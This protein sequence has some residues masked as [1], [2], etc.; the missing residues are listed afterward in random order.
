M[1]VGAVM[2][3]VATL[4][5]SRRETMVR[6]TSRI[7]TT[8]V[9]ALG[10]IALTGCRESGGGDAGGEDGVADVDSSTDDSSDGAGEDSD[11][12]A[13]D[14]DNGGGVDGSD[15]QKPASVQRPDPLY[16]S[17]SPFN[18]RIGSS[19][20]IDPNSSEMIEG[21]V[22][23]FDL[24]G[25]S[26]GVRESAI[27]VYE[28]NADTPVRDVRLAAEWTSATVFESIPVPDYAQP[29]PNNDREMALF[30]PVTRCEYDFWQVRNVDGRWVAS[31]AN[32]ISLDG[33]GF[34]SLSP[35]GARAGGSG[36]LGGL[37]WPQELTDGRIDHAL[38]FSHGETKSGG[39]VPPANQTDGWSDS[40]QAIPEGALLQLD[41]SFD[42]NSLQYE[43]ERVIALALQEYGMYLLDSTAGGLQLYAVNPL[44][45][46]AE[47]YELTIPEERW[48]EDQWVE[49]TIPVDRFRVLEMGPQDPDPPQGL[50]S[51]AGCGVHSGGG[52][53]EGVW[54]LF[55]TGEHAYLAAGVAG[56]QIV[57]VSDPADP[58]LVG[59]VGADDLEPAVSVYVSGH[60]AYVGTDG[61]G[62]QIIDVSDP[63][64]PQ[65]VGSF[66]EDDELSIIG[67][68][69]H[70][71]TAYA[72]GDASFYVLDV[73]DPADPQEVGGLGESERLDNVRDVTIEGNCNRSRAN[74]D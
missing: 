29:D 61:S 67:V 35:G 30:D 42:I 47:P 9:F 10:I 21:L 39:P 48:E 58:K 53:R 8:I 36:L 32:S 14:A 34:F 57:D 46:S 33:T 52:W 6:E 55:V 68:E 45:V 28:V 40:D 73:S 4:D 65:I 62:L 70:G 54:K 66:G 37:I 3:R 74:G 27:A 18:I 20:Q 44:S 69:V 23:Q 56:L 1:R 41:P 25:F 19:P 24:Q 2:K 12:G 26:I 16:S 15:G 59:S 49:L 71:D 13:D 64:D 43:F 11:N 51:A 31:W 72:G 22:R 50:A 17:D 38:I 7:L 60:L 63:A 5:D